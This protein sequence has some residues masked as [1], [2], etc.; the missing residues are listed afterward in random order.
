[1]KMTINGHYRGSGRSQNRG[2]EDTK[3]NFI[4]R[5]MSKEDIDRGLDELIVQISYIGQILQTNIEEN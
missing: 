5:R 2:K 3:E 1:M 4:K